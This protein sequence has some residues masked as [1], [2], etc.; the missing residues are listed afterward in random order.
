MNIAVIGA[1]KVG[2][3]LAEKWAKKGHKIIIGAKDPSTKQH[4]TE[5]D[6]ISVSKID[7]AVENVEVILVAVPVPAIVEIAES[8]GDLSGK[9][10]I[11]A[12][13]SVFTKP[14]PYETGFSAFQ[15]INNAKLVKGFNTTGFENLKDTE[16]E[17]KPIDMFMAGSDVEAKDVMRQLSLDAGFENCY[18]F[19]GD[20]KV[21]L[22]EQFAFAWINLAIMQGE[23]RNIAFKVLKR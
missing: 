21:G 3:T 20:D 5:I 11:D 13:N 23:G 16:Y 4:W 6:N 18:D 9:I 8:L 12:T 22:V 14:Q 10:I 1:G 17:G 19:G 15:T 2:G 7:D